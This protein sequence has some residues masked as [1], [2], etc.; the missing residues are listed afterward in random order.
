MQDC[1]YRPDKMQKKVSNLKFCF[2]ISMPMR[3]GMS[4]YNRF[5]FSRGFEEVRS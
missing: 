4:N 3:D 2:I 5:M 1:D